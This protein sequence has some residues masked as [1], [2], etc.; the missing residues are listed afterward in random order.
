VLSVL[1]EAESASNSRQGRGPYAWCLVRT[2]L[3]H[4][5][6]A[7]GRSGGGAECAGS[8]RIQDQKI[9]VATE[10]LE[11]SEAPWVQ[12]VRRTLEG[13]I[14]MRSALSSGSGVRSCAHVT[15]HFSKSVEGHAWRGL[16]LKR[17][18]KNDGA[19]SK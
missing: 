19:P 17:D 2:G 9:N 14:K 6:S 3:R 10:R 11:A 5:C 16:R 15:L 8:P 1:Q 7:N 13:P 12:P 4:T 18:A